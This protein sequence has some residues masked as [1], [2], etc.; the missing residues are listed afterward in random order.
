MLKYIN[1]Q[2]WIYELCLDQQVRQYHVENNV[3]TTE[4]ILG[5]KPSISPS[6]YKSTDLLP[7]FSTPNKKDVPYFP[8]IYNEG[9]TCDLTTLKRF[10][11]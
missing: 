6:K 8:A 4:Y 9:T 10:V 5:H 1:S 7:S 11:I 2:W 3:V